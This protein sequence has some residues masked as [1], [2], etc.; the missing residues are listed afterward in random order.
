MQL[1]FAVVTCLVA[2]FSSSATRAN[3]LPFARE[4]FCKADLLCVCEIR[5]PAVEA[6]K[7]RLT[8][9]SPVGLGEIVVAVSDFP[10]GVPSTGSVVLVARLVNIGKDDVSYV[11]VP[12]SD[13]V[14]S[15]FEKV[16]SLK[17]R[18]P[19]VDAARMQYYLSSLSS[20]DDTIVQIAGHEL[21]LMK[22]TALYNPSN[23][24]AI[25]IA[26]KVATR[27][28][29]CER[30][31]WAIS[32]ILAASKLPTDT[33]VSAEWAGNYAPKE[34]DDIDRLTRWVM[35]LWC[36]SGDSGVNHMCN[37]EWYKSSVEVR[38]T[39]VLRALAR[40]RGL[41]PKVNKDRIV[42][43]LAA[44]L[45]DPLHRAEVIDELRSLGGWREIGLISRHFADSAP[46]SFVRDSA[47]RFIV[48]AAMANRDADGSEVY[49]NAIRQA[50]MLDR[51]A[52]NRAEL[53]I[54]Q[55]NNDNQM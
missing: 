20:R 42:T 45:D 7:V 26:R 54:K 15:W 36:A 43:L 1:K 51:D 29:Q 9:I 21:S 35:C 16:P 55:E 5:K 6:G 32:M 38:T 11:A 14:R 46:G 27:T 30:T 41:P 8:A 2:L 17:R 24:D 44:I 12:A 25:E 34:N 4:I 10:S 47:A 50:S 52:I 3:E 48:S 53:Y 49:I 13:R 40:F 28:D 18:D 22:W 37:T 39:V 33:A 19:A 31:Q 23:V